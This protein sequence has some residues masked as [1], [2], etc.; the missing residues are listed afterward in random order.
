VVASCHLAA[1]L[2]GSVWGACLVMRASHYI[3][4]TTV[5]VINHSMLLQN[6]HVVSKVCLAAHV[7]DIMVKGL[8][9]GRVYHFS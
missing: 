1:L 7:L 2:Q 5:V 3:Q 4:V 9:H 6:N 8:L